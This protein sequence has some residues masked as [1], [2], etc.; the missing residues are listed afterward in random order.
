[1]IAVTFALPAES[2]AFV[3]KLSHRKRD[4]AVVRGEL[5][6]SNIKHQISR[7]CVL[8]TGVG[9]REC[10]RLLPP[11]L[12]HLKLTNLELPFGAIDLLFERHAL[13]VSVTVLRR[14]GDFEVRVVK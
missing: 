7:V 1:M 13:D 9:S 12:Q 3:R 14:S 4:G 10:E 5:L 8:H 11:F 6:R 2:S